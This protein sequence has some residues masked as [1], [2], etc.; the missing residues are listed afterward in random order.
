MIFP[1]NFILIMNKTNGKAMC[2]LCLPAGVC[3]GTGEME[4]SEK[5]VSLFQ[6][7]KTKTNVIVPAT[8]QPV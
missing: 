5:M 8:K 1:D 2:H 6:N 7:N 3:E 4:R